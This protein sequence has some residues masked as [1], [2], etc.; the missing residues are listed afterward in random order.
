[1]SKVTTKVTL[2]KIAF[3]ASVIIMVI[4]LCNFAFQ[5]VVIDSYLEVTM[6]SYSPGACPSTLREKSYGANFPTDRFMSPIATKLLADAYYGRSNVPHDMR[7]NIDEFRL[8]RVIK[9]LK[10]GA[11][12]FVDTT[13]LASFFKIYY[14][15]ISV[16]FVLVSGDSDF[17]PTEI[18][19]SETISKKFLNNGSSII[20]WFAMNCAGNPGSA[21][22]T[23]LMNGV[24]QWNQQTEVMRQM[25]D[26]GLGIIQ[27]KVADQMAPRERIVEKMHEHLQDNVTR[28]F[29]VADSR[30][31]G[32]INGTSQ[33]PHK[34]S[35]LTNIKKFD[36]NIYKIVEKKN[37]SYSLLLSFNLHSNIAVRKPIWDY[38]CNDPN[39]T[40]FTYCTFSNRSQKAIYAMIDESKFV[41]SPPGKGL[42]CYRTY[43]SLYLGAY[44]VVLTS[45]LDEIYDNLPVLIVNSWRDVTEE[46]LNDT[47]HRFRHSVFDFDKLYT[48][49]WYHK[50]RSFGY[51]S[52]SYRGKEHKK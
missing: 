51:Q 36:G 16:P 32:Y 47:Y 15:M 46:L 52:Y 17:S 3:V 43:E 11:V 45:S 2:L 13:A 35:N 39:M 6:Y 22:F 18:V 14:G 42:D 48:K 28:T 20:H 34:M 29:N 5:N 7:N 31:I 1:M 37:T 38:F 30:N 27:G 25:Y 4:T 12:I 24:S 41:L 33:D 10:P 40:S 9:C 49:Y 19:D 50:F 21:R 23:C 26:A 44:V 8:G